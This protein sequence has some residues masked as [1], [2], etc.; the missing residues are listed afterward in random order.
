MQELSRIEQIRSRIEKDYEVERADRDFLVHY[1]QVNLA[2]LRKSA[3][4]WL[5]EQNWQE[6]Q[7]CAEFL[8]ATGINLDIGDL[9]QAGCHLKSAVEQKDAGTAGRILLKLDL[10]LADL[11]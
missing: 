10:I 7:Q 2:E 5:A 8:Q 3:E 6:L 9:R 1:V 11:L 4:T